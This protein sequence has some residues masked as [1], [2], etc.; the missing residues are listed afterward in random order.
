ML[1]K[2]WWLAAAIAAVGTTCPAT[3]AIGL[4]TQAAGTLVVHE[5]FDPSAGLFFEG[6]VSYLV[7]RRAGSGKVALR[8]SKAGLLHS[9]SVL[10]RGA[11][12]L[13]T[14]IR[15]C[16]GNCGL[17]DPPTNRCSAAFRLAAGRVVRA[18]VRRDA[19]GCRVSV[20]APS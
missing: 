5:K 1:A 17:L 8:Q 18:K 11:Y 4:R 20:D 16:D 19:T 13:R 6:Y 9:T 15:T 3:A 2:R 12:R 7:V 14:Y 10:P